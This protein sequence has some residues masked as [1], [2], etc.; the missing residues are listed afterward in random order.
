MRGD[1][2]LSADP[3][4]Y[5]KYNQQRYQ[6]MQTRPHALRDGARVLVDRIQLPSRETGNN[7]FLEFPKD[8][9]SFKAFLAGISR[10]AWMNRCA[11]IAQHECQTVFVRIF[12]PPS[13]IDRD[14]EFKVPNCFFGFSID[15]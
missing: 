12:Q 11:A 2:A 9:D 3:I 14:G 6:T 7:Y 15:F 5:R 4:K 1:Q 10:G 13:N 8:S